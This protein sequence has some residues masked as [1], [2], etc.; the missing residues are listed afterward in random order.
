MLCVVCCAACSSISDSLQLIQAW[1][2]GSYNVSSL[3]TRAIVHRATCPLTHGSEAD[4]LD[5]NTLL[6]EALTA[7]PTPKIAIV[8]EDTVSCLIGMLEELTDTIKSSAALPSNGLIVDLV[9]SR[10]WA[11]CMQSLLLVLSWNLDQSKALQMDAKDAAGTTNNSNS[12]QNTQQTSRSSTLSATIGKSKSLS[13]SVLAD[14]RRAQ[15]LFAE[16][17]ICLAPSHIHSQDEC[18]KAAA[19][20]AAN[21]ATNLIRMSSGSWTTNTV[22]GNQLSASTSASA[23]PKSKLLETDLLPVSCRRI[24]SLLNVSLTVFIYQVINALVA[25]NASVRML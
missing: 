11:T 5:R 18:T 6:V 20:L 10:N 24:C 2:S 14:L 16:Y 17:N 1:G 15:T 8:V 21:H 3:L 12:N 22:A 23:G 7:I 9:D 13:A 25:R 4:L 19:T